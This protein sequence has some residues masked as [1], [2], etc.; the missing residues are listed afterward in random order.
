MLRF[1]QDFGFGRSVLADE[2]KD[3]RWIQQ[4][5]IGNQTGDDT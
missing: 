5:D 1:A 2:V 3:P 4:M